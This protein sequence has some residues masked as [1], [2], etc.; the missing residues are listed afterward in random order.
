MI[1]H[2]QRL[3]GCPHTPSVWVPFPPVHSLK[4]TAKRITSRGAAKLYKR[5]P[6]VSGQHRRSRRAAD[7]TAGA[8]EGQV[9]APSAARHAFPERAPPSTWGT[10]SLPMKSAPPVPRTVA[11]SAWPAWPLAVLS[12]TGEGRREEMSPQRPR[13]MERTAARVTCV[14]VYGRRSPQAE[15]VPR[16]EA[17]MQGTR[18]RRGDRREQMQPAPL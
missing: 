6:S 3:L 7:R 10:R 2:T 11:G 18:K 16:G 14:T 1:K 15:E 13:C 5:T 8:L 9:R 17:Q 12:G 4:R